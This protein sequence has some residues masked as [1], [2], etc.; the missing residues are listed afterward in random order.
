[1]FGHLM[2]KSAILLISSLPSKFSD[3]TAVRYGMSVGL[4]WRL[5]V[6]ISNCLLLI[7]IAISAS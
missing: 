6:S 7:Y 1:M 5:N 3:V 2:L 4:I